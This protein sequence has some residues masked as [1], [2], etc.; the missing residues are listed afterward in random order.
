MAK[1]HLQIEWM[2]GARGMRGNHMNVSWPKGYRVLR[3]GE[4]LF[5]DLAAFKTKAAAE[6]AIEMDKLE[7]QADG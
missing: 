2:D 3:D 5:P 4:D 6:R 1:Y 7:E